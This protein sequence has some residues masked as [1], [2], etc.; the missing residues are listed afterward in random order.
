MN[1]Y[2]DHCTR[3]RTT[4]INQQNKHH[5]KPI[6]KFLS[7]LPGYC[8]IKALLFKFLTKTTKMSR[9]V[10]YSFYVLLLGQQTSPGNLANAIVIAKWH[11]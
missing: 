2:I 10:T 7:C 5:C 6:V 11:N 3:T 4:C 9:G 1:L 8:Y